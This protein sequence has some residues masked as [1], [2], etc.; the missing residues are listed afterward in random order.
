MRTTAS[1]SIKPPTMQI[2]LPRQTI[3]SNS[4]NSSPTANKHILWKKFTFHNKLTP[5][6]A[7]ITSWHKF[8]FN[9]T[10]SRIY[11]TNLPLGH[12]HV[13]W[14]KFLFDVYT[15]PMA[16]T[17]A[18][19]G[20]ELPSTTK[21]RLL[22]H[23]ISFYNINNYLPWHHNR[24]FTLY[25]SILHGTYSPSRLQFHLWRHTFALPGQIHGTYSPSAPHIR[26]LQHTFNSDST[27][28]LQHANSPSIV[29]NC[30]QWHI[31]VCHCMCPSY[32][33]NIRAHIRLRW[34]NFC[35]PWHKYALHG[36]FPFYDTLSPL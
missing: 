14:Q 35:L 7:Q 15:P 30:L 4:T 9:A 12:T 33:T 5:P 18:Y 28:H 34:C 6:M 29:N 26:L 3:A 31:Y 19:N 10:N 23:I 8:A 36:T 11:D 2:H 24:L 1:Y 32:G 17:F 16:H 27:Y 25:I 22:K 21:N 13:P 20:K